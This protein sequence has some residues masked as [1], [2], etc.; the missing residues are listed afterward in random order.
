[1]TKSEIEKLIDYLNDNIPEMVTAGNGYI[2]EEFEETGSHPIYCKMRS[3]YNLLREYPIEPEKTCG[4]NYKAMYEN[5][6]EE[7]TVARDLNEA[8]RD[9]MRRIE[10]RHAYNIGAVAAMETIF[11]RKFVPNK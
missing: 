6:M 11:G 1:M 5:A 9:D 8:L 4:P 3:V 2:G 10:I 7:L